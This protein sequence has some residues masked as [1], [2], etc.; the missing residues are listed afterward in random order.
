MNDPYRM[1]TTKWK[2]C[3]F[4]DDPILRDGQECDHP[5]NEKC[6]P[7]AGDDR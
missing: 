2:A 4:C 5:D 3:R 1:A 7:R 6:E